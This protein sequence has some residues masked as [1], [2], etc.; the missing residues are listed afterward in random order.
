MLNRIAISG[1]TYRG[2]RDSFYI[3]ISVCKDCDS[4]VQLYDLL[5]RGICGV[6]YKAIINAKNWQI[7]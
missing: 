1:C 7:V 5:N 4:F 6:R 2:I 3:V